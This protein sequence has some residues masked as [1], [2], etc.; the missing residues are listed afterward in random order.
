MDLS[1]E[2]QSPS[3]VLSDAIFVRDSKVE[4][5]ES[6]IEGGSRGISILG[7]SQAK[8]EGNTI[9]EAIIGGIFVGNES[10]ASLHENF[11]FKN[12]LA[13]IALSDKAKAQITKNRIGGNELDGIAIFDKAEAVIIKNVISGNGG[14]GIWAQKGA[15]VRGWLNRIFENKE[16]DLCGE[17]LDL[18]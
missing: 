15:T 2:P 12:I 7:D 3:S 14:C 9:S 8:I 16:G 5:L 6:S 11:I 13:G 18:S 4:I 10:R 1:L 17:T